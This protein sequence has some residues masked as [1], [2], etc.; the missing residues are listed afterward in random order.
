MNGSR[1]SAAHSACGRPHTAEATSAAAR[2]EEPS[3]H[4]SAVILLRVPDPGQLTSAAPLTGEL[5]AWYRQPGEVVHAG[6]LLYQISWPGFVIE[7]PAEFSGQLVQQHKKLR[8]Q[9]TPESPLADLQ[10][11]AGEASA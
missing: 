8:S 9:V 10:I 6:E 4:S 11:S 5:T 3:G 2:R 1:S 7:Y